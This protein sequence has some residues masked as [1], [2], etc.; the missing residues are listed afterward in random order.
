M[1]KMIAA[2]IAMTAMVFG[3]NS[4]PKFEIEDPG[5]TTSWAAP[6]K[7][8]NP[9]I[10][11]WEELSEKFSFFAQFQKGGNTLYETSYERPF[12]AYGEATKVVTVEAESELSGVKYA[13]GKLDTQKSEWDAKNG[14]WGTQVTR[15]QAFRLENAKYGADY[16]DSWYSTNAFFQKDT[17]KAGFPDAI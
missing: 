3:F 2:I 16:A 11:V 14:W 7:L 12:G 8:E 17:L 6:K 1:Q 13:E 9:K 10:T 15:T 4:C 5:Q